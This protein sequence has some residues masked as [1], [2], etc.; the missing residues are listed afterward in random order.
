MRL[1]A[2]AAT[3]IFVLSAGAPT[4]GA[5]ADPIALA[6]TSLEAP[7]EAQRSAAAE[8]LSKTEVDSALPVLTTAL[9]SPQV[10]RRLRALRALA[11]L[12]QN[13]SPAVDAIADGLSDSSPLV[14][15]QAAFALGEI[16]SA[17]P[18]STRA[19]MKALR[20]PDVQRDAS[21]ALHWSGPRIIPPLERMLKDPSPQFR[22]MVVLALGGLK[23][24]ATGALLAASRD[25]TDLVRGTALMQLGGIAPRTEVIRERLQQAARQE[26]GNAREIA[27]QQLAK[28]T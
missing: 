15:K 14:R 4:R 13:A 7:T 20:D 28:K 2:Q 26:K 18:A 12:R 8:A 22:K 25:S 5:N 19:L 10:E 9:K 16:P 1:L 23:A 17:T 24:H 3:L 6:N 27:K 11:H 21:G